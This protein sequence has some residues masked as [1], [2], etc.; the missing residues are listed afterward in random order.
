MRVSREIPVA[1]L[2]VAFALGGLTALSCSGDEQAASDDQDDG[3]GGEP[4]AT[5][6]T[7]GGTQAGGTS[8]TS[9]GGAQNAGGSSAEAG[10]PGSG[11][12]SP[13]DG[14]EGGS[15]SGRGG[16]GAES[17][18]TTGGA[19]GSGGSVGGSGGSNSGGSGGAS[20]GSGGATGGA[21]GTSTCGNG[22]VESAET[23][24]DANTTPNDGCSAGCSVESG[25]SCSAATCTGNTCTYA[26]PATFRDFNADSQAGGHPDFDPGI[27]GVRATQGLLEQ[28]LDSERKPVLV[29]ANAQTYLHGPSEFAEWYRESSRNVAIPGFVVL[30]GGP[31]ATF[32]NR[33]GAMGERWSGPEM[34]GNVVYGG[35]GTAGG[36]PGCVES[37]C[38]GRTCYDPCPAYGV[39]NTLA[40]CA[41]DITSV[42]D[43]TPLFYPIDTAA[44]ILT[45]TRYAAKVPEQYGWNGWPWESTVAETLGITT[46]I[47]TAIAPFP[48]AVHN[49]NFTSEMTI[50]VRYDADVPQVIEVDGDDDIW[51]FFNGRLAID[52]GGFHTPLG[53]SVQ[54]NG[55]TVTITE[56]LE[57][58]AINEPVVRT[59]ATS[60]FG[61]TD[62]GVYP[63]SIFHAERMREG[64]AF[65]LAL[66]GYDLEKSVCWG[67]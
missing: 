50:W 27:S 67:P 30:H 33:W 8:G 22:V 31:G 61:V 45:E 63:V 57:A 29:A 7:S 4:A 34:W 1:R 19:G 64:S 49:F 9:V 17:G 11:G 42:F 44:G 47:E 39:S 36:E 18:S 66:H 2:V 23:C 43:G 37:A 15:T 32:V 6:G 58:S 55:D 26:L 54:F 41:D 12:T 60:T 24:D 65:R 28:T 21:G 20:G 25:F 59:L 51:L 14:G 40:C 52:L 62:G 13:D 53:G 46:P 16:S 35:L 48:S 5:G 10:A 38:A 56:D 3:D